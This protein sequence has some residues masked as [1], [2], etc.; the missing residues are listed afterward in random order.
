[1]KVHY[2]TC[3]PVNGINENVYG[4]YPVDGDYLCHLLSTQ[5]CSLC[6]HDWLKPPPAAHPL[7]LHTSP[8]PTCPPTNS[9]TCAICDITVAV[10]KL[11]KIQ[12]C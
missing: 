1:M 6:L 7:P 2:R 10:K 5:Y 3:G 4:A 8:P 9:L 11:L 12:Q